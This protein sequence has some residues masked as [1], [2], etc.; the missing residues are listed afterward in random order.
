[1]LI[2]RIIACAVAAALAVCA[3]GCGSASAAKSSGKLSI[4]CTIFPE[5]DWVREIVGDTGS[6]DVTCLLTGGSD[7]HSYQPTAEDIM[8][9]SACDMLIYVGGES[10]KW[11]ADALKEA[12][13]EDM[14]VV[15]LMDALEGRTVEEEI[16]EGM[17]PEEE[18]EEEGEEEPEYDEHV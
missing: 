17:E 2:K 11:V 18:E 7:M 12:T 6:A 14:R 9:I 5:Y 1:M 4:V 3:A 16:K 8:K 10:D 13:N 15:N